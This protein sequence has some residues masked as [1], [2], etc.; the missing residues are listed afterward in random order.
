MKK[1]K[2]VSQH[3]YSLVEIM[4]VIVIIAIITTFA[5]SRFG[6]AKTNF[7][8]QNISRELKVNL[9]RARFDSVKRRAEVVGTVDSRAEVRILSPTSFT[10]K[11]DLNQNGT[12]DASDEKTINFTGQGDIKIVDKTLVFPVT[13]KFDRYGRIEAKDGTPKNVTPFFT[14]STEDAASVSPANADVIYVSPSGTVAMLKG[15]EAEPTFNSPANITV[16][17]ANSQINDELRVKQT[18]SSY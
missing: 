12:L 13:I 2:F 5:V 10:V 4:I 3:G 18:N 16:V 15:G 11:T 6:N 17:N 8:R 7:K 1:R 14:I 9:E